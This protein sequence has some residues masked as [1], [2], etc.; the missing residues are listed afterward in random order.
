MS[1][2]KLIH[3]SKREPS[4]NSFIFFFRF[5]LWL[6]PTT[7]EAVHRW[8]FLPSTHQWPHWGRGNGLIDQPWRV[9]LCQI[10]VQTRATPECWALRSN[11]D[12]LWRCDNRLCVLHMCGWVSLNFWC[13]GPQM[14]K[15]FRLWPK[16]FQ[17]INTITHWS[18]GNTQ[19]SVEKWF[20]NANFG[21][22]TWWFSNGT[23]LWWM[24]GLSG[25]HWFMLGLGA[26]RQQAITW[27]NVEQDLFYH[28][29][30]WGN[31]ELIANSCM[32]WRS[33]I[34]MYCIKTLPSMAYWH[35]S[36]ATLVQ[37]MACCMM[38]PSHNRTF[39]Y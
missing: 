39:V 4:H 2:F 24:P 7:V 12:P 25:Q 20:A 17:E 34:I 23:D 29:S 11:T 14:P 26:V 3:H 6:D 5:S 38:A 16:D 37:V 28:M 18:L 33:H 36:C 8:R 22:Y 15:D 31:N 13:L 19:T 32:E 35:G 9:S 27:T 10:K 1:R 30:T 21:K